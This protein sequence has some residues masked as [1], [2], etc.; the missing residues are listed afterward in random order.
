[1]LLGELLLD[2]SWLAP[3][4]GV[5]WMYYYSRNDLARRKALGDVRKDLDGA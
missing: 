4:G 2:Y 1:M 3:A 5:A